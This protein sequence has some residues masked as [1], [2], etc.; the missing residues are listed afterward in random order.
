MLR[1]IILYPVDKN[2]LLHRIRGRADL[3]PGVKHV[4]RQE[5]ATEVQ[6]QHTPG[7]KQFL[8][9]QVE[10]G[11]EQKHIQKSNI[12]GHDDNDIYCGVNCSQT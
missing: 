5:V 11:N 12:K 1:V 7:G 10:G 2:D 3:V 6:V 4:G 9:R 8:R